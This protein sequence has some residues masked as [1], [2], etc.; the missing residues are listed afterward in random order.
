MD[1]FYLRFLYTALKIN[2]V[3][4]STDS[5]EASAL[6][7]QQSFIQVYSNSWGPS[8]FGF[9]VAGPKELV[10]STFAMAVSDVS[11]CLARMCGI[12]PLKEQTRSLS[13]S[14]WFH[15]SGP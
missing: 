5:I 14:L 12:L 1:A 2:L 15:T 9:E 3:S 6:G 10:N 4:G 13:L 7:Y 11:D 8:D